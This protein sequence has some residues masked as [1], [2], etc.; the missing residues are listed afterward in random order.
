MWGRRDKGGIRG[1]ERTSTR[2]RCNFGCAQIEVNIWGGTT[3]CLRLP[4]MTW[5]LLPGLSW[6]LCAFMSNTTVSLPSSSFAITKQGRSWASVGL[7][8][9]LLQSKTLMI[10]YLSQEQE[11]IT[12]WY[13]TSW[14]PYTCPCTRGSEYESKWIYRGTTSNSEVVDHW[15]VQHYKSCNRLT[16][17]WIPCSPSCSKTD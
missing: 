7:A 2:V 14:R 15:C 10:F 1:K 13:A 17:I 8:Y 11:F 16:E 4:V 3:N 9:G 12:S 5:S 6:N